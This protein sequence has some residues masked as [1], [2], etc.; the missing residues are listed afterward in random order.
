ME[1]SYRV[2][3]FLGM[4]CKQCATIKPGMEKGMLQGTIGEQ[5]LKYEDYF[6]SSC[7]REN[8]SLQAEY[9]QYQ[10]FFAEA[11]EACFSCNGRNSYIYSY[12]MTLIDAISCKKITD[13]SMDSVGATVSKLADFPRKKI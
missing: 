12:A 8:I 11:S 1:Q 7:E 9:A 10:K 13:S 6:A 3:G 5:F 2:I 4:M